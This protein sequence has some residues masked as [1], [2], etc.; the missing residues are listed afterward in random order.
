MYS[1]YFTVPGLGG[2]SAGKPPAH[3]GM[4]SGTAAGRFSS[5]DAQPATA[6]ARSGEAK[7]NASLGVRTVIC[8]REPLKRI[9]LWLLSAS[10]SERIR[11][12]QKIGLLW[13]VEV[14]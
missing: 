7:R 1:S 9:A 8:C 12:K 5:M 14:V 10:T 6:L 13:R 2:A 3:R 4:V 11:L